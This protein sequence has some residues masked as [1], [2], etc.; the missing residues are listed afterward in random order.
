MFSQKKERLWF[1]S[2][3]IL[4]TDCLNDETSL[5]W[6]AEN[7]KLIYCGLTQYAKDKSDFF[8]QKE[9]KGFGILRLEFSQENLSNP[10]VVVLYIKLK[11][12]KI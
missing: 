10:N 3:F 12:Y 6:R 8:G 11:L 5:F 9:A 7:D 2:L 1:N 4:E